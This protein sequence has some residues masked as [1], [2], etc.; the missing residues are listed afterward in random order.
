[1]VTE[2]AASPSVAMIM[3]A[4][5]IQDTEYSNESFAG[6]AMDRISVVAALVKNVVDPHGLCGRERRACCVK[7]NAR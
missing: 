7:L 4:S 1:M 2:T 6:T 3:P 5:Q